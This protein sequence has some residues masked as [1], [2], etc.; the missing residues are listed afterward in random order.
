LRIPRQLLSLALALPLVAASAVGVSGASRHLAAGPHYGGTIIADSTS[1]PASLDPATG[2]DTETLNFIEAMYDTLVQF[3]PTG[4]KLEPDLATSWSQVGNTYTFTIR[5]SVHFWNGDLLT[6]QDVAFTLTRIVTPSVGTSDLGP[7]LDI[8]GVTAFEKGKA[9]T[10]SGIQV[11]GDQVIVKLVQPET[12]FLPTLATAVGSILDEKFVLAHKGNIKGVAMGTGPFMFQ[13]WVPGVSLTMVR[14]PHYWQKG[15][16]YVSKIVVKMNINPELEYEQFQQHEVD[17]IGGSLS[18]SDQI[19]SAAY[20]QVRLNQTEL[21]DNYLRATIPQEYNIQI[22][23]YGPLKSELVRQAIAHAIQPAPILAQMNG[24]AVAGGSLVPPGLAGYSASL[25]PLAFNLA[26]AKKLMAEAGYKNGFT[27]Q[28][29]TVNDPETMN[30]DQVIQSQL[31]RIGIK[32]Q[33]KALS[34]G[35]YIADDLK[36]GGA[37][38]EWGFWDAQFP[39]GTNFMFGQFDS[40]STYVVAGF[41]D[42]TVNNLINAAD[43]STSTAVQAKLL[44]EA[45]KILIDKDVPAVPIAYGVSDVLH[46]TDL[47]PSK[48]VYFLHPIYE[49]QWKYLRF[50]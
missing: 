12:Y 30:I 31:A 25:K 46:A 44:I 47:G 13:S 50:Q 24:R 11:K 18:S 17:L 49:I 35:A 15:L 6:P 21:T 28:L 9:K 36:F 45:Q 32:V 34:I 5:K 7:F 43:V 26:L 10:V 38:L 23:P 3:S 48:A 27:T 8:Q 37:P 16:P 20:L 29:V 22:Q 42:P 19:G 40:A 33:V 2:A 1:E 4:L 39:S 14:N 41:K